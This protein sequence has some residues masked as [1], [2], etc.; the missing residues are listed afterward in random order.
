M[1]NKIFISYLSH[2]LEILRTKNNSVSHGH[3]S[4]HSKVTEDIMIKITK[5]L[6]EE[7]KID[8]LFSGVGLNCNNGKLIEKNI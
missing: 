3:S 1:T 4:F 5:S 8:N 7:F 6:K 2:L